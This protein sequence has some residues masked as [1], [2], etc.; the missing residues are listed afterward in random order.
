VKVEWDE[1]FFNAQQEEASVYWVCF[2]AGDDIEQPA[3][4]DP[5]RITAAT[6]I[7][8]VLTWLHA[9][10]GERRFELFVETPGQTET[11]DVGRNS[12]RSLI[13]LAGDFRPGGTSFTI[14]LTRP[15]ADSV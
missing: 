8:G 14:S 11:R 4:H 15:E 10:K 2:W 1:S 9:T 5:Q 7:E 6:S 3:R 12:Y 13:R